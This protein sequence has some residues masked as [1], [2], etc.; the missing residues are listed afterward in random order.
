[1]KTTQG[2]WLI[3]Q[4]KR[5][6]H[7]YLDLLLYRVSVCPWK[8]VAETLLPDE[9]IVKGKRGDLVTWRVTSTQK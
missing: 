8:R 2:R 4:L 3:A 6:P 7:T 5:K 1:M 9:Q